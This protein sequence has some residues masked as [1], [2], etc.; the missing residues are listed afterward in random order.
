[1]TEHLVI[2]L[3]PEIFSFYTKNFL[4]MGFEINFAIRWYGLMY[5]IGFLVGGQILKYLSD[6][7]IF[8]LNKEK[9]DQFLMQLIV[10]M[11][12]GARL[13]YVLIYNWDYYSNHVNEIFAV[14]NGGLSFH[15]AAVGFCT[16][17]YIVAKKNNVHF[18]QISDG[19]AF[20]CTPGLFFG[21]VGNFINGELFGRISD[22]PWAMIF[23]PHGG[24]YPRHPSQ[25]YEALFEGLFIFIIFWAFKNK[26]KIQGIYSS[27]FV[28]GYALVRFF[29]EFYRQPD[30]QLGYYLNE[31]LTMGQ[32]LCL[33]MFMIGLFM[34][35]YA[36]KVKIQIK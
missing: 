6:K 1:M 33:F 35:I 8:S 11:I 21:R 7:N 14:W 32:I 15:G 24:P 4:W 36:K 13:F 26:I 22:V 12:I 34:L 9:I 17:M 20:A 3:S 28:M 10:G 23:K 31:T 2:N 27:L 16:V 19:V 30:S 25:L 29:V 5:V 18:F